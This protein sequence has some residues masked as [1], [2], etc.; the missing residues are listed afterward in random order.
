MNTKKF[1]TLKGYE[2]I[3]GK[4]ITY[5]MEDYLEMIYRLC[6]EKDYIRTKEVAQSLNVKPSSVTKMVN[7]LKHCGLVNFEKYGDISLTNQGKDLGEYLLYRHNVL[8]KFLCYI[9]S[10]ESELEQV[11]KIEHFVNK[12]TV[13]N[14]EKLYRTLLE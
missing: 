5:A 8:H 2:I 1:H 14:I 4:K 10:S 13:K 7:N 11:E 6:K 3:E 12:K 9:N